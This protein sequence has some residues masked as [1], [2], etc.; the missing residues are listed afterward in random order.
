MCDT[1]LLN[2]ACI[3]WHNAFK[4]HLLIL[5]YTYHYCYFTYQFSLVPHD[6]ILNWRKP[7]E[8]DVESIANLS[9]KVDA[10][11]EP[12]QPLDGHDVCGIDHVLVLSIGGHVHQSAQH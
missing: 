4:Y 1:N 7:Q 3:L 2:I 9:D 6:P 11:K 10:W 5:Q 8:P 12:S